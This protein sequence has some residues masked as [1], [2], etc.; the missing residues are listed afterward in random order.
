MVRI[1]VLTPSAN[2]EEERTEIDIKLTQDSTALIQDLSDE[3][4]DD[5]F[6]EWEIISTAK[7]LYAKL[8]LPPGYLTWD[9]VRTEMKNFKELDEAIKYLMQRSF[10]REGIVELDE[11]NRK[12]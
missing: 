10:I 3:T 6:R 4:P 9:E 5:K 11:G 8:C 1:G 7:L 2:T 12:E